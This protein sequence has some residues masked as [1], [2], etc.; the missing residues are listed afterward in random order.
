MKIKVL[1]WP[2]Q[3]PDLNPIERTKE[4]GSAGFTTNIQ[5]LKTICVEERAKI[6][7]EQC[8]PLVTS[9]KKLLEAVITKQRLLH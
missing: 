9:Y 6:T 4:K 8:G 7:S 2:S 1:E 5:D 3:S